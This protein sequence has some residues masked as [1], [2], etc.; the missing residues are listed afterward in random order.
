MWINVNT[1]EIAK[2]K[3]SILCSNSKRIFRRKMRRGIIIVIWW[4]SICFAKI[5]TCEEHFYLFILI[6]VR[7]NGFIFIYKYS[8]SKTCMNTYV[9]IDK[10]FMINTHWWFHGLICIQR[11]Q[12]KVNENIYLQS[13]S[14][15]KDEV[16]NSYFYKITE[17]SFKYM[18]I[19][20]GRNYLS[21]NLENHRK[22]NNVTNT[23]T[24]WEHI[25][26][27]GH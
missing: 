2:S 7:F 10:I 24:Q 21:N 5:F 27:N 18:E 6:F 3:V 16:Y 9:Y 14:D 1:R 23:I 12:L 11:C 25:K 8:Y 17:K 22:F 20:F 4:I 13:F 19:V 15:P 26:R